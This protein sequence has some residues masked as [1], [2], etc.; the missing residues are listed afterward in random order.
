M[1][2]PLI[3]L[4][5]L[6]EAKAALAGAS[7]PSPADSVLEAMITGV[8]TQFQS[9]LSRNLVSQPYSVVLDGSGG[10]RISLPNTP[11]TAVTDLS[12]DGRAWSAASSPTAAGVV[13]SETQVYLRGGRFT[14]GVQ[15]VVLTYTAGYSPIPEDIK[16]AVY[17]ALC[18][19]LAMFAITG[20]P[21]TIE[22]KAGDTAFKLASGTVV[23]LSKVCISGNI[24]SVL[25]ERRRVVPC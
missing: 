9:Y 18:A 16:R 13:F 17:E 19:I 4:V 2:D 22:F 21:R 5:T 10:D 12:V 23:E 3:D 6:S 7:I 24:T 1:A 15:N 20:D 25:N 8:S 14:R 11:I